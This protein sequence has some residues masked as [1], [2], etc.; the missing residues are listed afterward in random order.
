MANPGKITEID[1][2]SDGVFGKLYQP[3]DGEVHRG[4][5][6][7]GGSGGGLGWSQDVARRLAEENYAA[8]ALAYFRYGP[9]P[10]TLAAIPLEYFEAAI[11]WMGRQRQI[12]TARLAVIGGSRGAELALILATVCPRVRAV[13]AYAPSCVSWGPLGGIGSFGKSAWTYRG[14]QMPYVRMGISPA[15]LREYV[16]MTV[17]AL[18]HRPY[19]STSLFLVALSNTASVKKALIPVEK[20][21]GPILLISGK[22]D[23]LW[24][25]SVMSR[26]IVEKLA[27]AGFAFPCKH[28]DYEGAGHAIGLPGLPLD[29]YPT[30]VTHSVTHRIYSLGGAPDKNAQAA[31]LAWAEVISFLNE[32]IGP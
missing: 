7:V 32:H 28:L 21:R 16:R 6:V 13:V 2:G 14:Q 4:L 17:C 22:E 10:K 31:E 9:L 25:A 27:A 18:L 8:L 20:I 29:A 3:G 15:I 24:P 23:R 19:A 12:D 11:D 26:I 30:Q 1:V 5:L